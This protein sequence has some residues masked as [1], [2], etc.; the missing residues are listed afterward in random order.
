V[1]PERNHVVGELVRA[2]VL[3]P[4]EHEVLEQV[5]ETRF[6]PGLRFRAH[7]IPHLH[8]DKRRIVGF[9]NQGAQAV[10]EIHLMQVS[11]RKLDRTSSGRFASQQKQP[12]AN[13]SRVA[14]GLRDEN[15]DGNAFRS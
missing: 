7:V 4:I 10:R 8:V 13:T 3:R 9:N 12:A 6:S 11:R 14:A 5:R 2:Q 1:P 15:E